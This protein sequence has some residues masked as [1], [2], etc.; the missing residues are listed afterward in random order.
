MRP[1]ARRWLTPPV[2]LPLESGV[3]LFKQNLG[4]VDEEGRGS[5]WDIMLRVAAR[6]P[7]S[8]SLK[9]CVFSLRRILIGSG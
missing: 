1:V 8:P 3:S 5:F 7:A 2:R 9:T 6:D 4:S